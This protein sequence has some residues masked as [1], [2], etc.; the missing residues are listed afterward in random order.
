M[1]LAFSSNFPYIMHHS[2][3]ISV[4]LQTGNNVVVISNIRGCPAEVDMPDSE[5]AYPVSRR[6]SVVNLSLFLTV[7]ALFVV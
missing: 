4:F 3:V 2:R 7:Y 1:L 6:R 5:K